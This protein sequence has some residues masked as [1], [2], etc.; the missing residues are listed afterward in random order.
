MNDYKTLKVQHKAEEKVLELTFHRPE[1]NNAIN[2]QLLSDINQALD[3][4]E[5]QDEIRTIVLRGDK[6]FFCTG[7]DFKEVSQQKEFRLEEEQNRA[8]EY[9]Q[10]LKRFAA[11]PK[12]IVSICEGKV[13]AGGVGIAAASDIV[14]AA[15]SA[16]FSLS[17]AIWG[18][19]PA[20]VL[21]YLIRRA[22]FQPSYL[23][24]L[25]TKSISA[26]EAKNFHLVDFLSD[27]PDKEFRKLNQRLSVLHP[28]TLARMKSYFRK[29]WIINEEM[30]QLAINTLAEL[31]MDPMVQ[32][33]IKNYIQYQ[34]F[35]WETIPGKS[36]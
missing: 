21:P 24:T 10:T 18:L 1:V 33:N 29:M 25:T 31:K 28:S 5:S 14:I 6:K 13:T 27:D 4:A 23:M 2:S 17:E 34:K 32:Q 22:G 7:M 3:F 15:P 16:Q 8:A 30:E 26:E 36:D 12:S 11:I 19:L 9:C 20:N 35:P